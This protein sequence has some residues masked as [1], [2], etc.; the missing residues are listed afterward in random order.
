M[1][2]D[3]AI[4]IQA[5]TEVEPLAVAKLLKGIAGEENPGLVILGSRR[6]TMA[7]TKPV[8]CSPRCWAAPKARSPARSKMPRPSSR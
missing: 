3:C 1:G 8:R 4:L 6:S 2:A 7:P 5:D